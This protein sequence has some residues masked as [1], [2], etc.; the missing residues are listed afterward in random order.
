MC[1][2]VGILDQG[3]LVSESVVDGDLEERYLEAT[4]GRTS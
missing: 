4:K 3:V 2:R 1:T